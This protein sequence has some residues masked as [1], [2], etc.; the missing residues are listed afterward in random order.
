MRG[1]E[2]FST[3]VNLFK[4]EQT[5]SSFLFYVHHRYYKKT[6]KIIISEHYPHYPMGSKMFAIFFAEDDK[7]TTTKAFVLS[8][9]KGSDTV[10]AGFF[11]GCCC[12]SGTISG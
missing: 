5:N 2:L 6:N 4:T 1:P 7:S 10:D 3:P 12:A 11:R 8:L 9:I